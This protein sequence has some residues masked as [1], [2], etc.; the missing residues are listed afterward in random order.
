[1]PGYIY[2]E[3]LNDRQITWEFKSELGIVKKKVTILIDFK[4]WNELNKVCFELKRKN[5]DYIGEGYF[6]VKA[7]NKNKTRITG[8][9]EI[10]TSGAIG[11]LAK[12]LFNSTIPKSAEQAAAAISSKLAE[13]NRR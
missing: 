2:H 6:E 11:S 4:E 8:F 5:E 9:F 10:N 7:L 1:V 12:S 13:F 3:A